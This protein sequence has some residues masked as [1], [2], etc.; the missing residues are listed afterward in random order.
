MTKQLNIRT[1][2]TQLESGE[3]TAKEVAVQRLEMVKKSSGVFTS[4]NQYLVDEAI[5]ID[6][7]RASGCHGSPLAGV[8]ITLKDLF[9]M[10]GQATL[11]ASKALEGI[12]PIEDADADVV[13]PLR[14]AGMLVAGRTNM[15]EFAF[16]GMGRNPH[17]PS[18]I[19]VWDQQTGRLPGGSSSGSAVS[20]AMGM[21][22]GTLGSDTAGSCRIPAAFNGI[23]GVKPTHGRLSLKGVYP[24]SPTSDAPGPLA[25]DVDSC[26]LLDHFMRGAYQPTEGLPSIDLID[27]S[28]IRVL[29][30]EGVVMSELDE[31]VSS[32]FEVALTWLEQAGCKV[33]RS[34]MPVID[35]CA[36]LFLTRPVVP[37]EAWQHHQHMIEAKGD[38]YDPFVA[39]RTRAAS[40]ISVEEQQ[41]RY[42]DK[43]RCVTRFNQAFTESK[44]DLVVYPTV[45]CIPPALSEI[46]D[47]ADMPAVNLRCLRNTATVNYFDGC[48]ISVPCHHPGD[49]PVGL[50]LSAMGGHDQRLYTFASVIEKVIDSQRRRG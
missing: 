20:V 13:A 27:I 25:V 49:A 48:S 28:D 4:T 14:Q 23:V 10:K 6:N 32:T 39:G 29:V 34:S 26:F 36:E 17:F 16:S 7:D 19:S 30:P 47:P 42:D 33:V 35:D 2:S 44:I 9:G 50:M 22:P 21:V 24:L 3:T 41:S 15:S 12:A 40:R 38:L 45:Q 31:V 43:A 11:A 46:E 8:P 37:Y 1:L 5:Q 18:L